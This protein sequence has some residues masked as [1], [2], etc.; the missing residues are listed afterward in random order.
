MKLVDGNAVSRMLAL[1]GAIPNPRFDP[2]PN[3]AQM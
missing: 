2:Y 1:P 3:P